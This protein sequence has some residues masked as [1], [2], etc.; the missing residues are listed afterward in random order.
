M[1]RC[2]HIDC[3]LRSTES[4]RTPLELVAWHTFASNDTPLASLGF[5]G[6]AAVP[7]LACVCDPCSRKLSL[8][9]VPCARCSN[10]MIDEGLRVP[11]D[12]KRLCRFCAPVPKIAAANPDDRMPKTWAACVAESRRPDSPTAVALRRIVE[13]WQRKK[14]LARIV[15]RSE[16]A[17]NAWQ[18]KRAFGDALSD[19]EA[20]R[21]AK[22]ARFGSVIPE[23][24]TACEFLLEHPFFRS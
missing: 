24:T 19:D 13:R 15:R 3:P 12:T 14:D 17:H 11:D 2:D 5:R 4:G 18:L 16:M 1:T 21:L 20:D 9:T 7:A 23:G 22:R 10:L 6:S 8:P